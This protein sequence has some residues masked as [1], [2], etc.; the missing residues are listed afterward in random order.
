VSP[1]VLKTL[2]SSARKQCLA[3][4]LD[5]AH[6][7][8]AINTERPE[9]SAFGS[10]MASSLV[11]FF[12]DTSKQRLLA[13]IWFA[14]GVVLFGFVVWQQYPTLA[15]HPQ[16]GTRTLIRMNVSLMLKPWNFLPWAVLV[17][18]GII[19]PWKMRSV[20]RQYPDLKGIFLMCSV[21]VLCF[22]ADL[23]ISR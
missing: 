3:A 21:A 19:W 9:R 1:F 17:I 7:G 13:R 15:A 23:L 10:I 22:I 5:L 18:T 4:L 14:A 8:A 16:V 20:W 6:H 2:H 12:T 11:R